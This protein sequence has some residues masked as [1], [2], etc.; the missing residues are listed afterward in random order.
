MLTIRSLPSGVDLLALQRRAPARFP[1]LLESVASGTAQGRWDMLLASDGARISLGRDGR[2]VREDGSVAGANFLAAL[3]A[4]W[5]A[6]RLPRE[7]PLWPFRGGWALL[8]GYELAAEVEPV[9]SLP[10]AEGML[11]VAVACRCPGAVLRDRASG[12]VVAVAERGYEALL[13]AIVADAMSAAAPPPPGWPGVI[14]CEEDLGETYLHGVARALDYIRAGDVFQ[15]N[16]SRGWDV[17]FDAPLEPAALYQRLRLANPAPFAGLFDLGDAGAV[18]SASPERLVSVRGDVVETRPIAGTR[19]RLAGDDDAGRIRE[20][21]GHAKERAEHVMLVDLERNDL[22]RVCQAGSVEVD[23]LMVVESYA[24][25]HH[26]VSNVRGRLRADATPGAVLR[27]V[28]PGGTITGAPK[29]RCMQVIAELEGVGRGAYTG[30]MG[31][32]N[33]D[34]DLDLN[35]LIRSAEVAGAQLRFRTGA[36]IVADS[37]PAHELDETRAK[38]RGMLQALGLTGDAVGKVS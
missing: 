8:L 9:L 1:L 14:A 20:L 32:L 19:P 3:D 12:E 10:A 37:D 33:R 34:G 2:S 5:Q 7:E 17:R 24:H 23:E 16:L 25:V 11:P 6:L 38:A 26:I 30:A 15:V 31:W 36:G 21:V 22:G 29:V 13:E 4:D 35:I 28:F 18:V 27:A